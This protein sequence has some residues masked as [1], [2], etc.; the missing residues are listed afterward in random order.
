MRLVIWSVLL[1]L[2]LSPTLR[3]Q[4]NESLLTLDRIFASGDF[5]GEFA[6]DVRWFGENSYVALRSS[7]SSKGKRNI[8]RIEKNG[9]TSVL[10]AAEDLVATDTQGMIDIQGFEF[11]KDLDLV[12]IYTNSVKVWRQNT[13]GDYWLFRRSTKSLTKIGSSAPPSQLMFAKLSP[14]GQNV[15]YVLANNLYMQNVGSGAIAQ[16]THDGTNDIING[17]F[18]WV[19]EEEFDCRD[20]W[21]WSPDGKRIAY[22]Q[23]NTTDVPTFTMIDN[24]T[25]KYPKLQPFKYPKTGE[26]NPEWRIG[27]IGVA[28]KGET[29]WLDLSK[30]EKEETYLPR[31]EWNESSDGLFVRQIN[32]RQNAISLI[33][34]DIA[35]GKSN[36]LLSDKD[37]AWLDLHD[38]VHG[39]VLGGKLI[40]W[41]SE[42]DGWRSFYL[43]ERSNG[44]LQRITNFEFDVIRVVKIDERLGK[45]YFI[46]SPDKPADRYLFSTSLDGKGKAT[47]I[48]PADQSGW[49]EYN[50][51]PDGSIAYHSFSSFGSPVQSEL[52]SLFDHKTIRTLTKNEALKEKLK[53]LDQTPV[54]F[55]KIEIGK[56]SSGN[57][58]AQA[59]SLANASGYQLDAWM[60]KP[61]NFDPS[62]KY[63][64][65]FHV[66]GEPAGQT[67]VNRWG[68]SNYLWHLMLSQMGY[69]V[70]SVDNRGTPAPRGRE[71]RKSVYREIGTLASAD[72]AAAA[73]WLLKEHKYLDETRVGVWG[74][75]GGGSMT[76]NLLF[77][78]PDIYKVGMSIAPVPDMHLYDTIY[79]ERYMG[80]PQENEEKYVNGSPI[81][82]AAGLAGELLIVHG[83]GDDNCHYQGVEKL[84]NRL[85][86]LNKPFS[87]MAYPNRSHSINEGANT[88]RHLYGMLTR[89]LEKN[90]PAGPR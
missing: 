38:D 71:W 21:R 77:R 53:K 12:L 11:S 17:T 70:V 32:R 88:S 31:M 35:T 14:D 85:I 68:G 10:V 42:K 23:L 3:A 65:L 30:D 62:K 84:V 86:E 74:W 48:T 80:I 82:H 69:V 52:I 54:E 13:R 33:A 24:T 8:V 37:D 51:S 40:P 16:L 64:L 19:Y 39:F 18:D 56:E 2:L 7:D 75:S 89:F 49:H 1:A 67:V 66:Y 63:P 22:W 34:V 27:V 25:L 78:S 41:I 36:R 81:T 9:D 59:S 28:E 47:R 45:V 90:L 58:S 79:Q 83:T 43:G 61:P 44:N 29:K 55:F 46:A 26:K 60:I 4:E 76:L 20:G 73:R 15:G 72:Q 6:S 87:M 57:E 50:I 5:H